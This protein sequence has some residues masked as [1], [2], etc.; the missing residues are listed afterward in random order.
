MRFAGLARTLTA[1]L[2]V[3]LAGCGAPQPIPKRV[4][5]IGTDNAFPYHYMKPDGSVEGLTADLIQEA[6]R[7]TG[8]RLR[9]QVNP[10]GPSAALKANRVDL[11]SLLAV[12]PSLWPELHFSRPYLTNGFVVVGS[13]D[14][15]TESDGLKS[16]RRLSAV[17]L[18]FVSKLARETMPWAA[19]VLFPTRQQAFE[20]VCQGGADAM[21]MEARAAHGFML[22][23][24]AGCETVGLHAVG[25]P[26]ALQNLGIAATKEAAAVAD[27]LRDEL[28][29]MLADGTTARL[30]NRWSYFYSGE[31]ENLFR[32][33][34][35]HAAQRR[36]ML[37]VGLLGI[38]CTL[39]FVLAVRFRSAQRA[40]QSANRVKSHFVAN[41]SHEMRTP[42]HG[43]LGVSRILS[44]TRLDAE[45]REHVEMIESS[46]RTLLALVNDVLDVA[47]LERGAISLVE[48]VVALRDLIRETLRTFEIHASGKGVTLEAQGLEN[49]PPY[50]LAD[51]GRLRQILTNLLG[52]AVKFTAQGRISFTARSVDSGGTHWLWMAVADTGIGMTPDQLKHVFEKFYQADARRFP[53]TGLGLPITKTLVEA[54]GGQIEASSKYGEGSTFQ[55]R[56][57]L[58]VA[59][60]PTIVDVPA[61]T[62]APVNA[63]TCILVVEDNVVNQRIVQKLLEREGYRVSTA[64][65]AES[66]LSLYTPGQFGAV[67]MDCQLPGIDGYEATRQIR[68][69]DD[70]KGRTPIIAL[71]A[72]AMPGERERCLDA[73]MDDY[74]AKPVQVEE[75]QEKLR[76]WIHRR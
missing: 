58:K 51:G 76:Q 8:I 67:L 24:P 69:R 66:A 29:S 60:S 34:Q 74:L 46:G 68:L 16:I 9:W 55:V 45:Q 39:L 5:R 59:E 2:F 38:C 32:Q 31:A 71:T 30:L 3:A 36:S 33:E 37:M 18:P 70:G 15:I 65:D 48:E 27:L 54:M 17:S 53:G 73:G 63:G 11:W 42:L 28:D 23:R 19:V 61:E 72:A 41:M 10:E 47:Q 64:K 40:A 35:A 57:P 21:F 56:I 43:I 13:K 26:V 25:A 1:G 6:A 7:R 22:R 12:Q 50:V 44:S 4:Y 14:A 75:L 49:L 52:N 20:A 62:A